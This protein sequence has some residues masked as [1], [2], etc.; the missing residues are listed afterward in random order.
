MTT[1][2]SPSG[3]YPAS[4]REGRRP[5]SGVLPKKSIPSLFLNSPDPAALLDEEG[6][7]LSVNEAATVEGTPGPSAGGAA[8]ERLLPFWSDPVGLS[9]LLEAAA[10]PEGVR[11]VEVVVPGTGVLP[12]RIFWVSVR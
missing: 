7:V 4:T 9:R 6:R 8:I 11:N 10:R 12:D 5:A 2:R 1:R 3:I